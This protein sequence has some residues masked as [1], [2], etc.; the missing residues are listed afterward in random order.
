MRNTIL[1]IEW[2]SFGNDYIIK[3]FEKEGYVVEKYG[4]DTKK[5]DTRLDMEQTEKLVKTLRGKPYASVFWV[6]Y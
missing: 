1:F 3:A 5:T 2:K 6:N 4:L